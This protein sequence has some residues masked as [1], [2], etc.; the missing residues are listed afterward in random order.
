MPKDVGQNDTDQL[1]FFTAGKQRMII[2]SS[3]NN[4]Y[5]GINNNNPKYE[6]DVSGVING[7]IGKFVTN[8][9]DYSDINK[10]KV[11]YPNDFL[12][13]RDKIFDNLSD[14]LNMQYKILNNQI[15]ITGTNTNKT[16]TY[17]INNIDKNTLY[18]IN[19]INLLQVSFFNLNTNNTDIDINTLVPNNIELTKENYIKI[20]NNGNFI[21]FQN[22][23]D[24]SNNNIVPYDHKFTKENQNIG[25]DI[26]KDSS[27]THAISN[28]DNWIF[29]TMFM[30]PE[31]FNDLSYNQ[32]GTSIEIKWVLPKRYK[33]AYAFNDGDDI[34]TI[35]G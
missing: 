28:I 9:N 25:L 4:G 24:L 13:Y 7:K 2:D 30:Q 18:T 15:T 10:N 22:M 33:L 31:R 11:K 32:F 19:D 12:V 27:I 34:K 17:T 3:Y 6:L 26:D 1:T 8:N 20:A 21:I 16:V 29:K 23:F 14:L 35:N 5:I